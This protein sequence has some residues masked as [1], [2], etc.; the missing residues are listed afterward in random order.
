MKGF[1]YYVAGTS[2]GTETSGAFRFMLVGM[3]PAFSFP[4]LRKLLASSFLFVM[5]WSFSV[6][7]IYRT[8]FLPIVLDTL[9][10][11]VTFQFGNSCFLVLENFLESFVEYLLPL[12]YFFW[13]LYE[14]PII[15]KSDILEKNAIILFDL[16]V[17]LF[18]LSQVACEP[19]C[20]LD[21]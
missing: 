11:G 8:V 4:P 9:Y 1:F 21:Q 15:W 20:K 18:S 12:I 3:W 6:M 13:F 19:N 16:F 14:T 17:V 2:F 10:H 7:C 5:F